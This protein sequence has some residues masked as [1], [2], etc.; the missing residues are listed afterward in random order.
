MSSVKSNQRGI[1]LADRGWLDEAL[2]EFDR[3]IELDTA[4]PFPRIN[5]ASV[6]LEQGRYLD[7]LEDLIAAVGLAP[8][9]AATHYHLGMFLSRFGS[10]MAI[11]QLRASLDL[12]PDQIDALLQLGATH[13]ELGETSQAQQAFQAALDI[14][15]Q[16]PVVNRELGVLYMEQEKIHEA[17]HHLK[18]AHQQL[19]EDMDIQVDLGMAYIHAGFYEKAQMLLT[20]V[21]DKDQDNLHAHYNLAAIYAEWEKV[22]KAIHHLKR[23]AA[24]GCIRVRDWLMEDRMFDNL[25]SDQRFVQLVEGDRPPEVG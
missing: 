12:D 11:N 23:A 16:D 5:R 15:P 7:A 1:E 3:A 24:I 13:A 10:S 21:L 18:F 25:R 20:S 22:D 6:F 2:R 8:G 4:S 14:D 19:P 9:E 17:I